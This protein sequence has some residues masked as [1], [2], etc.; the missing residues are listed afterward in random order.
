MIRL[1]LSE[2]VQDSYTESDQGCE[3]PPVPN[4]AWVALKKNLNNTSVFFKWGLFFTRGDYR[5]TI[6]SVDV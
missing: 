3:K 4:F 2:E 1:A 6:T 5:V